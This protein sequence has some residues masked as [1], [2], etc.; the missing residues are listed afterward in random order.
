MSGALLV[1]G[2]N[3]DAGKSVLVAGLA[4]QLA[5]TG[6]KVAPFKAANMALNSM[7]T[8]DGGEIG[9]A[10]AMQ[11][12]AARVTA[13]AAMNPILVKPG[14]RG[15]SHVSVLG[16]PYAD[17]DAIGYQ[18]RK[19]ELLEVACTALAELRTR[20]DVVLCEGA[21]SPA[22]V[23][24]R[25]GDIA[26][27]GLARAADLP[28]IVVGDI[29]R[30]GVFA[31]F[32]GTLA[33]LEP[34]DQAHLA[35]FVVNK[36]RGDATL[37][38]PGLD[39][40]AETTGRPCL[41]VLPWTEGLWLDV[42]DSLDLDRRPRPAQQPVGSDV[43]RVA[44]LRLPRMSNVTDFDPLSA[45]PGVAVSLVTHPAELAGADLVVLPG[46]RATVDD[47]AW[48]TT[49]GFDTELAHRAATGGAVLGICGGLQM[50]GGRIDD[51]VESG[52]G[53]VAGLGLLPVRT[54]FEPAKVLRHSN[55]T[56][57]GQPVS[58][59]EIHHG[60]VEVVGGAAEFPGGCRQGAVY[61]TSWHGIFESDGFRRGFLAEVAAGNGRD[62]QPGG[63]SFAAVREMRLDALANLVAGHLDLPAIM[64]L[65]S[66]GRPAGLPT[67]TLGRHR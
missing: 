8:A 23:N 63:A 35:G 41:G 43:L 33:V 30:G 12:A 5:R 37:L 46:T 47:L 31:H 17:L 65:I 34:A 39:W 21:G 9:R 53:C 18:A 29:D 15:R 32:A 48:L 2:T 28:V 61:G 55:G 7:V 10:Q 49:R 56:W 59:Y 3:S 50:L 64:D 14:G 58:G 25:A 66:G 67:I 11:A 54:R 19:G 45:E 62:W 13:E 16:A 38:T 36:F 24:L 4:R 57:A 20:F 51:P 27:L 40:L 42:E 60:R 44:V 22:E 26:N 52:A 1:A 6:V